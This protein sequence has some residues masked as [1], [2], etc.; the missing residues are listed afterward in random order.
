MSRGF[1]STFGAGTADA[2]AFKTF[3]TFPTK[4][5]YAFWVNRNGTGAIGNGRFLQCTSFNSFTAGGGNAWLTFQP[6]FTG[7]NGSFGVA[8]TVTDGTWVHFAVAY[9][10][11]ATTNSPNIYFNGVVQPFFAQTF[12]S[13]GTFNVTNVTPIIG[14]NAITGGIRNFDGF[15]AHFAIWN[16]LLTAPD[17]FLLSNGVNPLLVRPENLVG[18]LLLDGVSSPEFDYINGPVSSVTGTR[19]GVKDPAVVLNSAELPFT[20]TIQPP[21]IAPPTGSVLIH[22]KRRGQPGSVQRGT[23]GAIGGMVFN[24]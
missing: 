12:P 17:A 9:D 13:S 2:V 14:N 22:H 4:F 5:T 1:G 23:G 19:L 16:T 24:T 10:G 8:P 6:S 18:Y 3:A 15:F 20:S 21:D 7:G 11:S